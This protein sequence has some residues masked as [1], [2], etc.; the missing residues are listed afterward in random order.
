MCERAVGSGWEGERK[1]RCREESE[2]KREKE[3]E[4][5][6]WSMT[7]RVEILQIFPRIKKEM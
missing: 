6:F 5:C 7:S 2:S 4:L 3:R 1:E